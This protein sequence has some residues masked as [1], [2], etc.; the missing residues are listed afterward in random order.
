MAEPN[1]LTSEERAQGHILACV[2]RPVG[3]CV[4]EVP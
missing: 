4:V 1:C 3:P 2:S